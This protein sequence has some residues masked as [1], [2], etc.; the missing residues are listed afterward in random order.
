M[1]KTFALIMA[2]VMIVSLF[3]G[4]QSGGNTAATTAAPASTT[5]A[6]AASTT[7]AAA[8][9]TAAAPA[10]EAPTEFTWFH[11]AA[12]QTFPDG[13]SFVD[14]WFVDAIEEMANVK[15]TE[16]ICPEYQDTQT[17]FN[18]MMASGEIPDL[19]ERASVSEMKDY[20]EQGAFLDMEPIIRGSAVISAEY[21]D[22]QL[23]GMRSNDGVLYTLVAPPILSDVEC[24]VVRW[25]L[26][27]ELGYD[28]IPTDIDEI[29]E[30]CRKLKEAY[31]DS[32][33]LT[34][35]ALGYRSYWMI[36]P[37]DTN[38][39]GVMY[40]PAI[41]A[42]RNAW[43]C[44]GIVESVKW[45]NQLYTE[46]LLDPEFVTSNSEDNQNKRSN[47]KVLYSST[48]SGA[49]K[50]WALWGLEVDP[51]AELVPIPVPMHES[52]GK[53]AYYSS[54]GLIGTYAWA[55]N[56]NVD[57]DKIPGITRFLEAFYSD[58]VY[59][60]STYGRLGV[61]YEIVDGVPKALPG[62]NEQAWKN[63]YGFMCIN[64]I[65][66]VLFNWTENIGLLSDLPDAQKTELQA[67]IMDNYANLIEV[68]LTDNTYYNPGSFAPQIADEVSNRANN[69][70]EVQKN[71]YLEAVL[72]TITIDQFIAERDALV[73][74][75]QDV[76]DAYNANIADV[77]A[78]YDLPFTVE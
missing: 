53:D 30:A 43:D 42:F 45:V 55:I 22:T 63:L 6:A 15:L 1:K 39:S 24:F 3:A 38:F 72:G 48:N 26:L 11:Q 28:Y 59:E 2:L 49:G 32:I 19:I 75:Y 78:N 64:N 56:A 31:P 33:P 54:T 44:Q 50:S 16:V 41:G 8:A 34:G 27:K 58:E 69:M 68:E 13:F 74:E 29:T 23:D 20:G 62:A 65:D 7:K 73:A 4:C 66:Q 57:E 35:P 40:D 60:M 9:T 10:V 17:K 67:T 46:G 37:F 61:E 18:L 47:R 51:S 21:N 5:K 25:D 77:L 71:L 52:T 14:N 36:V 76:V 12:G 70:A